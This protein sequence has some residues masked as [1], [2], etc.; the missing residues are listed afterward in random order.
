MSQCPLFW[1]FDDEEGSTRW[2]QTHAC[3]W[4]HIEIEWRLNGCMAH[5]SIMKFTP[6]G[7]FS[8]VVIVNPLPWLA[9]CVSPLNWAAHYFVCVCVWSLVKLAWGRRNF[10]RGSYFFHAERLT[11]RG[12]IIPP[13]II[14]SQLPSPPPYCKDGCRNIGGGDKLR[15]IEEKDSKKKNWRENLTQKFDGNK[16]QKMT[17]NFFAANRLFCDNYPLIFFKFFRQI[18]PPIL[19][20]IIRKKIFSSIFCNL[21]SSSI[22][23]P[24]SVFTSS[25]MYVSHWLMSKIA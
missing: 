25:G 23:C 5:I 20:P 21:F 12:K 1:M 3:G 22:N 14:P 17:K 11:T 13:L 24:A 18:L 4:V 19:S 16:Y 15:K 9:G 10:E 2:T 7:S 6:L 8:C